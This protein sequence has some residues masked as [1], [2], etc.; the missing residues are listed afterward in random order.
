MTAAGGSSEV[1]VGISACL[2]G[3]K[4]RWNA[5]HERDAFLVDTVG[6]FVRFV[7]VC[8]EVELGLGVP[9]ETLRLVRHGN[10]VRM[11]AKKSGIDHTD[12]MTR[13]SRERAKE[14]A[15]LDLS[16]FVLKKDSPSCGLLRVRVYDH[17]GVPSKDG[18]GLFAAALAAE[19]PDLPLEE[20][21]RLHDPRLR[22]NFFERIFAYRR[23]TGLFA[24][25]WSLG[26]LVAFHSREK[27]L[28]LAHEPAGYQDLGR[29]VARA[30]GRPRAELSTAYRSRFLAALA[31]LATP[32]RHVNVLQHML[33]YLREHLDVDGRRE[34]AGAIEDFRRGLVPLVVPLTLLKHHVR[35]FG[36][37]YLSMQTYLDPHPKELMLRNHV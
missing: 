20:E 34:L 13:F 37:A 17:H 29:L 14:I 26:G 31:R 7:S 36:I 30:K 23:V 33:G 9:R 4:V 18:T 12:A 32:H 22:E 3:E 24:S 15:A 25:P 19:L 35:R 28:L 11:V 16:G 10:V 27:L 6:R 21:G 1:S 8:P 2:V 5:G